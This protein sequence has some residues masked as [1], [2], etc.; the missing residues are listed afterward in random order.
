MSNYIAKLDE[1]LHQNGKI[2]EICTLIET[3][4]KIQRKYLAII[5]LVLASGLILTSMA[6]LMVNLIAFLY[7]AFKSI[8]ALESKDKDDDTK[9]LTYWVVYGFFSVIEFFT[10]LLISWFPFYFIAKTIFFIWCMSPI[11]KNGS[12][13]IYQHIILP[14]FLKNQGKLDE[15]FNKAKDL[16][17][18][19]IEEA[20]KAAT[21]AAAD[22]LKQD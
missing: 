8:K 19:G 11:E 1:I 20:T 3:K 13:M 21:N 2:D 10:D 12:K 9:W 7:P 17:Q 4:T 6:S 16:A 5:V 14:W 22:S 18:N 15:A